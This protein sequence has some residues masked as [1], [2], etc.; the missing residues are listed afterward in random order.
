MKPARGPQIFTLIE[1]LVV[2]A[3]IAILAGML[4][5]ALNKAREM[6]HSTACKSSIK[7]L[8]LASYGYLDDNKGWVP[9][10]YWTYTT[11]GQPTYASI[12]QYLGAKTPYDT[13]ITKAFDC[14]AA[15]FEYKDS[16]GVRVSYYK[17][18]YL[19]SIGG[20]L[21]MYPRN[22][23][24]FGRG[25]TQSPT[26]SKVMWW[27]DSGDC[28]GWNGAGCWMYGFM[29]WSCIS[30]PVAGH[31]GGSDVRQTGFRHRDH[32]N[33]CTLAGNISQMKGYRGMAATAFWSAADM[34]AYTQWRICRAGYASRNWDLTRTGAAVY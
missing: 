29:D 18:R 1:L 24:E 22:I 16:S 6:A 8:Y 4:L 17:I 2:I 21:F 5:P 19:A 26:P 12:G 3:M 30:N 27:A 31:G 11:I 7:Q 33:F 13:I 32:A 14:P 9:G 25:G 15:R 20:H 10:T 23:N 34:P 28:T